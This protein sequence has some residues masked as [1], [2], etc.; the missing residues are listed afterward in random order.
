M[1]SG[2]RDYLE[3]VK[4]KIQEKIQGE[5]NIMGKVYHV[6]LRHGAM[7]EASYK[8]PQYRKSQMSFC[9]IVKV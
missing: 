5:N 2:V 8:K 7:G 1:K 3:K 6:K 4:G 9:C